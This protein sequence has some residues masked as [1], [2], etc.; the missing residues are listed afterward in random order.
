MD[1]GVKYVMGKMI[2]WREREKWRENETNLEQ[3]HSHATSLL[4][5]DRHHGDL[6]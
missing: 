1:I 4:G 2:K 6:S 3:Y 5:D